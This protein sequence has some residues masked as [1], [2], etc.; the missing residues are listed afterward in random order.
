MSRRVLHTLVIAM[1]VAATGCGGGGETTSTTECVEIGVD[2]I[3]TTVFDDSESPVM[4][5][6]VGDGEV[7]SEEA[8]VP[9]EDPCAESSEAL[10][11]QGATTDEAHAEEEVSEA[12]GATDEAHAEEEAATEEGTTEEDAHAEEGATEEA[13]HTEEGATD[14]EAAGESMEEPTVETAAPVLRSEET[15]AEETPAEETPA[16]EPAAEE[17]AAEEPAS[18]DPCAEVVDA[19]M[20]PSDDCVHEAVETPTVDTAAAVLRSEEAPEEATEEATAEEAVTEDPCV[21]ESE[22]VVEAVTECTDDTATE[23]AAGET[24]TVATAA[25]IMRS[26]EATEESADEVP[27]E[28][29]DVADAESSDT[30][31]DPCTEAN[32]EC[33]SPTESASPSTTV[34]TDAEMTDAESTDAESTDAQSTDAQASEEPASDTEMADA[35]PV[36]EPTVETAAPVLRSEEA[37]AE[38]PAAEEPAAEE[39]AAEEPAVTAVALCAPL[40]GEG[41]LTFISEFASRTSGTAAIVDIVHM[42]SSGASDDVK[43]FADRLAEI[44]AADLDTVRALLTEWG[45]TVTFESHEI[46]ATDQA[47]YDLLSVATGVDFDR[48]WLRMAAGHLLGTAALAEHASATATNPSLQELAAGMA[49]QLQLEAQT[50]I[51]HLKS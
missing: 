38:E 42:E 11:A 37:P 32:V 16:E 36:E 8:P 7:A 10:T 19:A 49:E 25:P 2:G 18:V 17:P 22:P 31:A 50:M 34:V 43:A 26:E 3:P 46:L 27:T 44:E 21:T 51:D 39:P 45:E 9:C 47:A 48:L 20:E 12:E 23:T 28:A 30:G 14:E 1:I 33:A 13:A 35:P 4:D 40:Y 5:E 15:P 29:A 6:A 41:D 24:P